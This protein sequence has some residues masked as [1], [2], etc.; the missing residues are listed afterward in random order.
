MR[1]VREPQHPATASAADS[2]G[3]DARRLSADRGA[4]RHRGAPGRRRRATNRC[5]ISSTSPTP[6]ANASS[7][8]AQST[9]KV[10]VAGRA[11]W[12][13]RRARR[14]HR[15]RAHRD[16]PR[17]AT[18]N[19]S[20]SQ[21]YKVA[22]TPAATQA[23]LPGRLRSAH[24][25]VHCTEHADRGLYDP[26]RLRQGAAAPGR[27]RSAAPASRAEDRRRGDGQ[28][29]IDNR[30]A[31][32]LALARQIKTP[33]GRDR[34]GLCPPAPKAQPPRKRSG[35]RTARAMTLWK[36]AGAC[37]RAAHRRG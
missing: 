6:R 10:G 27:Q 33:S 30:R 11:A 4:G 12:A 2:G 26:R 28:S 15:A 3:A 31:R 35:Q 8:G 9:I 19:R 34:R 13:G 37:Q 14:L 21:V 1:L 23:R 18:R 22:A 32:E 17:R 16:S 24:A 29:R 25:A 36:A 5:A 20:F 7:Q